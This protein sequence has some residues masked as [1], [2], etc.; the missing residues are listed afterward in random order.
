MFSTA[1][2]ETVTGAGVCCSVLLGSYH[3]VTAITGQYDDINGRGVVGDA[4]ASILG[5]ILTAIVE[6][7]RMLISHEGT[8]WN[9]SNHELK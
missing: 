8:S 9:I 6:R 3:S 7:G 5:F 1:R 4:D 2:Q